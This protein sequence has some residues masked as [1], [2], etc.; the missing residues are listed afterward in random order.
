MLGVRSG[1]PMRFQYCRKRLM[2]LVVQI[3]AGLIRRFHSMR[4]GAGA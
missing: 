2:S 3:A 1:V 4:V